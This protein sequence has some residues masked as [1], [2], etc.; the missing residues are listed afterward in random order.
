MSLQWSS[1]LIAPKTEK[2]PFVFYGG[3]EAELRSDLKIL[4]ELEKVEASWQLVYSD[5]FSKICLYKIK[6]RLCNKYPR[7]K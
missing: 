1:L 4:Q 6:S 3:Q 2:L 5:L 7:P